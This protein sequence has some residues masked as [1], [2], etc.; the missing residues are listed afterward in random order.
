MKI[1]TDPGNI[2]KLSLEKEG[3]NWG[4]RSFLKSCDISDQRIDKTVQKFFKYVSKKIDCSKCNNCCKEIKPILKQDDVIKMAR[5]LNVTVKE[6]KKKFLEKDKPGDGFVFN[7]KPCPFLKDNTCSVFD[8]RPQDCLSY[9]YIFQNGF[10]KRLISVIHHC[11]VCPI[12][13]NVFELLKEEIWAMD[14][15]DFDPDEDL[16]T[17][18]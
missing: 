10:Q 13:Y 2:K 4:F 12:V 6:F 16:D 8:F 7:Q 18:E 5:E 11:S 14:D 3:E 9:P 1:E 15:S 17:L